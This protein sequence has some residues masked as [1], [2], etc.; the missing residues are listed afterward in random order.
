MLREELKYIFQFIEITNKFL[1][2]DEMDEESLFKPDVIVDILFEKGLLFFVI[3][4]NAHVGAHKVRISFNKKITGVNGT[5]VISDLAIFKKL[6]YLA[7]HKDIKI[8]LDIATSYFARKDNPTEIV[9]VIEWT[10]DRGN[11]FDRKIMHNLLVYKDL[12]YLTNI[13]Y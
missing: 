8:F 12:G 7:P 6:E 13:D 2:C 5:Q 4:N 11:A 1:Y 3:S 10:D 9:I